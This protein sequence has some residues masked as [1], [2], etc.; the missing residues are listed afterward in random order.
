MIESI[1]IESNLREDARVRKIVDKYSRARVITCEHYGEVFNRK[2]QHFRLQKQAPALILANKLG[3]KIYPVPSNQGIGAPHNYY[4]SHML[5]CP[6]DCRYCF[7]QGKFASANY[8]LFTN[9]EDFLSEINDAI[10]AHN[11][12]VHVFSGYDCDSLAFEPISEFT[13]WLI[14]HLTQAPNY[15]VELR[16][17]SAQI[18]TLLKRSPHPN[19][20]VAYSLAP[21]LVIENVEFGTARLHDRL[22]ALNT[23]QEAGWTIALRLDPLLNFRLAE[24]HY[25]EFFELIAKS[26]KLD[27]VHSVTFGTMRFPDAYLDKI[28][29]LYPDNALLSSLHES[30]NGLTSYSPEII[31]NLLSQ[32]FKFFADNID[33][34]RL[35]L[36]QTADSVTR[37]HA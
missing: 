3:R 7:L 11:E 8:V 10:A 36:H 20:L 21:E 4:F 37:L 24:S 23:L 12:M 14:D 34:S 19:V 29:K 31:D 35:F 15:L 6:F 16:T 2:N 22:R 28:A 26:I 1:Y 33:A 25:R 18:R 32:A 9:Y 27:R 30:D 13:A 5:N 17:K